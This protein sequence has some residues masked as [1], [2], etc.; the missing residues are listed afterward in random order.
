MSDVENPGQEADP[1]EGDDQGH[2][3]EETET[4]DEI[5]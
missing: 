2:E 5:S 1:N 4:E 3:A